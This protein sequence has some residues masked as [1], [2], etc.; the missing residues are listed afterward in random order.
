MNQVLVFI[1]ARMGSTRLPGKVLAPIG[2]RPLILWTVAAVAAVAD[3][4]DLVVATTDGREDDVLTS[5]LQAEG[6]RVH[7]GSEHDV[8]RRVADAILAGTKDEKEQQAPSPEDKE[9]A[10]TGAEAEGTAEPEEPAEA[11]AESASGQKTVQQ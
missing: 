6:V 9:A 10:D 11:P 4:A 5:L 8:L 7:R 2:G 1:Q 3:L